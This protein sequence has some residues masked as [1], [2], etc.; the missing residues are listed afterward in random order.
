LRRWYIR[1][2]FVETEERQFAHLP[3]AV[4]YLEFSLRNDDGR[5]SPPEV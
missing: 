2:G 1:M 3:F 4:Q 5:R